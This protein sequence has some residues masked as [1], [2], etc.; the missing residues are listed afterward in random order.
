MNKDIV[1]IP[2]FNCEK[3][4]AKIIEEI[5][6]LDEQLDILI[7]DDGSSDNSQSQIVRLEVN[8]QKL[9]INRGVGEALVKGISYALAHK[10][11]R[12]ITLDSDG[13][14]D[15]ADIPKF[16]HKQIIMESN[17][18]IGNRWHSNNQFIPTQKILANKLA[19]NIFNKI[20]GQ[21]LSDIACGFRLLSREFAKDLLHKNYPKRYGFLYFMAFLAD[22]KFSIDNVDISVRY[23]ANDILITK[24]TEFIN[25]LDIFIEKSKV[26]NFQ[27]SLI[28][29][30]N[31]ILDNETIYIQINDSHEVIQLILHPI[32]QQGYLF[33]LQ[34]PYFLE[35]QSK[36]IIQL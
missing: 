31:K 19:S 22:N 13:A 3:S 29:L 23:N 28:M 8:S 2:C 26:R 15:P 4:I 7:I 11:E 35:E 32:N 36:D 16:L 21:T 27:K 25:M 34:H 33:Q 10:Y 1:V 6:A 30:Q 12:I 24:S 18:I 9:Q 17:L 5:N 14:H 20:T